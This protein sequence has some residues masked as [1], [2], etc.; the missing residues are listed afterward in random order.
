MT[1][2]AEDVRSALARF[3]RR[4][5]PDGS[6]KPAAVALVVCTDAARR[7]GLLITKRAATLRAHSGQWALPGGRC[8][9]GETAV[10]SALRELHEEIGLE[11]TPAEVLGQLDD[12]TTRSGYVMNP[13]VLWG[14][15]NPHLTP[16]AA[17][18]ESV[19][20]VTYAELDAEPRY[21]TEPGSGAELIQIP[22]LGTS[23]HAPTGAI[24]FQ[25]R[26]VVLHGRPTRVAHLAQPGWAW[27]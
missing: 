14:G 3:D 4:P 16:A 12:F 20:H 10:E 2:I 9:P 26:E 1:D 18:V 17:E 7:P 24:L 19:H 23:I 5:A 13:V 11:L 27:K 15:H 6:G 22:V 25:F 8:D 21:V